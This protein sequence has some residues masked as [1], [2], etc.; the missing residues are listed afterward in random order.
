MPFLDEADKSALE[1]IITLSE[2]DSAILK[3]KPGKAPG[4]DGYPIEFFKRFA[5]KS[6]P[7]LSKVFEEILVNKA[8]PLTM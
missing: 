5:P 3:M 6:L 8:L 2:I 4:P 7:L 1:G